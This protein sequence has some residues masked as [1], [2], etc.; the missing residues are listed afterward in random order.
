[1]YV[2]VSGSVFDGNGKVDEI[3]SGQCL[4]LVLHTCCVGSIHVRAPT[5]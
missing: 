2:N 4:Y 5:C 1:M 3:I